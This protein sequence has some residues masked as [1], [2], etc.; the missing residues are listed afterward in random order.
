MP[1]LHQGGYDVIHQM[2]QTVDITIHYHDYI[3][4]YN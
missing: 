4:F 1:M 3:Y 2:K